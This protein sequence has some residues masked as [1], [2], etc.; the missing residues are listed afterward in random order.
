[1]PSNASR[2]AIYM[3]GS[4]LGFSVMSVL[5]KVASET[6]PTGE[7][8]LARTVVT[9]VL[10]YAML[11][12]ARLPIWGHQRKRLVLRGVLGF[13]GLTC[14]YASLAH[15]PLADATTIQNTTPLLTSALAWWLLR[16]RVGWST[17]VAVAC[18]IGGVLLI[19][20]PSGSGGGGVGLA[21]A[22]GAVASSA[23]AYVTVRQ[24]SRTEHPLTVVFYFPL[25]ATPLA[26]PWAAADWVT[27]S[28]LE[29]VLLLAIGV[30]TQIGQVFLTKALMIE[31]AGRV[32]SMGYIQVV[33]A[34][35]W[36][37]FL[38]GDPP[39]AL[40]IAGAALIVVGTLAVA[41]RQ[42]PPATPSP[43]PA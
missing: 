12:H 41:A 19:V 22:L 1:M 18:G 43:P 9:L 26:I 24:L 5:V 37:T 15:L 33:F 34:L 21:F 23:V 10:S 39:P 27:P 31:R 30:T 16:E 29:W 28:P 32:T 4:A 40:S 17:A 8:V 42:A 36:Q 20:H 6:L 35:A 11:V 7:L 14:Y 13:C 25:V 2:A 3:V 38:F